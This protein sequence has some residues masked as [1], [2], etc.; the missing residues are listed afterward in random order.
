M[1]KNTATSLPILTI[2]NDNY[3]KKNR[4]TVA[5]I[6]KPSIEKEIEE[7]SVD[8]LRNDLLQLKKPSPVRKNST[9]KFK[10]ISKTRLAKY[11]SGKFQVKSQF[12]KV[13]EEEKKQVDLKSTK[14]AMIPIKNMTV[15]S[16]D[17]EPI[18][19]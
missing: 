11:N 6:Q 14:P 2:K 10:I 13:K 17:H 4:K 19:Q 5:R 18:I 1:T 9:P 12:F 15:K 3:L 16:D 8:T 7:R